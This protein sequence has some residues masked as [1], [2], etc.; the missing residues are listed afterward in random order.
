MLKLVVHKVTATLQTVKVNCAEKLELSVCL[1][2]CLFVCLFVTVAV[3]YCG[4][5]AC[6]LF[7][8]VMKPRSVQFPGAFSRIN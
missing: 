7:I 2:V 1:S 8:N 5:L 3:C 6:V 4:S